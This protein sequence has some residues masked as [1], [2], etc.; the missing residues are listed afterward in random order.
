M[1][2]TRKNMTTVLRSLIKLM[3]CGISIILWSGTAAESRAQ[4]L[5]KA[6]ILPV[7]DTNQTYLEL[8]F[9]GDIKQEQWPE[10]VKAIQNN[11]RW[12]RKEEGNQAFSLYQPEDGKLQ[13]IW[14][15]RYKDTATHNAHMKQGHFKNAMQVIKRSLKGEARSIYLKELNKIP[16]KIPLL[17]EKPKLTRHVVVLFD[18]K[19]EKRKAF[20]DLMSNVAKKSRKLPGNLEFNIYRYAEDANKFVLLEGWKTIAD[21]EAQ[22]KHPFIKQLGIAM[23]DFFVTSPMDTRWL[24]KDLSQ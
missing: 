8:G 21:H 2:Y 6:A 15:E 19:T 24:V 13:P 4:Q 1:I 16:A 17:S 12:S 20:I 22:M 10:F 9:F 7:I 23:K 18:V 3:I 11:I 14:F 5:V